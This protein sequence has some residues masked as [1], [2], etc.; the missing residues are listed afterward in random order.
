MTPPTVRPEARPQSADHP[1][2]FETITLEVDQA[3]ATITLNRPEHRNAWTLLMDAEV[4]EALAVCDADDGIRVVIVTGAGEC[5]C[6]GAD[7]SGRDIAAPGGTVPTAARPRIAPFE[8]RK[9]IIAAINGHAVGIGITFPMQCD[10]RIV[11][12]SA[13]VGFPF[14]RRGVISELNGHWL[15][16][17]LIGFSA[18]AQ[19]L[20]TGRLITGAEAVTIGLCSQARPADEVLPAALAL[21]AELATVTAPA[22]VAASKRM[23]WDALEMSR[24]DAA[25][26]EV[27]LFRWLAAQPDATEGVASFLERRD[28]VWSMPP[29]TH[30]PD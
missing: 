5:F 26:R 27:Q 24:V 12:E 15:L 4:G 6:V 16:P 25:D 20:L 17:R 23:L 13:K 19:L 14:V 2:E 28:P 9:P 8:M 7:L 10:V 22:A 29:S 18:A 30:L 11:A 1:A 3:I 21:G